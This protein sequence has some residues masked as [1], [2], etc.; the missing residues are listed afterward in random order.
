MAKDDK[1]IQKANNGQRRQDTK[2]I[3]KRKVQKVNVQVKSMAVKAV[4]QVLK[5]I[6]WL[7]I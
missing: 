6:T 4:L 1:W 2:S 5:L 7:K 3:S